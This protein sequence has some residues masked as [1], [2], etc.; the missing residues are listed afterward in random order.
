MLVRRIPLLVLVVAGLLAAAPRSARAEEL[1]VL[2]NGTVFRGEVLRETEDELVVKLAGFGRD[3]RVTLEKKRIVRRSVTRYTSGPLAVPTPT[4][5]VREPEEA[6]ERPSLDARPT[7]IET[8]SAEREPVVEPPIH[9]ENFFQRLARVA[10]LG[11]PKEPAGRVV[12]GA[13]LLIALL[14]IVGMGGRMAEIETLSLG[15]ATFLAALL[16]AAL[17]ADVFWHSHLLRADRALWVL[18]SQGF[19]WL[20]AAVATLRENV[21]RVVLLFAFVLFSVAIVVFSAGA[22]LVTF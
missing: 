4:E 2:D 18:P 20:A 19:A 3:A 15:R 6:G 8:S 21:G 10:V 13:L 9:G 11:L 17:A 22:I 1:F 5:T 12:L 16:G 14:A 7:W